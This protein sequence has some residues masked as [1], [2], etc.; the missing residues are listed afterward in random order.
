MGGLAQ[1]FQPPAG[2]NF[3]VVGANG[4]VLPG[5]RLIQP[6][7]TQIETGPG[8]FGLAV[9]PAGVIA[10]ADVGS[11]RFGVTIVEPPAKNGPWRLRHVWARTPHSTAPEFAPPDWT[12]VTAGIAFGA[13]KSIWITEGSSGRIREIHS[14]TGDHGKIV[15]L[16]TAEWTNSYTADLA[17]DST[18]RLINVVDQSNARLAIIDEKSGRALSSV[19]LDAA[20]FAIALSPD[21]LTAYIAEAKAVCAVDLRDPMHPVVLGHIPAPSPEAVLA[22]GDRIYVSNALNDSIT[23]I[24]AADRQV[25]AEISLAVSPLEKFRG[26][27]PA[28]MAYD[29][30][31][32]WLL[33]AE[34][35]L[36]TVGIVDTTTNR[37]IGMIPAAWQPTRVALAGDRVYVTNA[38]GRGTGPNPRRAILELGEIYMLHRGSV[39]TFIMPAKSELPKLTSLAFSLNGFVLNKKEPPHLPP[40]RHVVLIVKSGRTFDEVMGD[41]ATASNGPVQSLRKM[42]VFGIHGFAEGGRKQ[43][44]V[45]D[46]A[47]TP[48]QHEI[49]HRWAF[50]DNFYASGETRAEGEYWLNGGYPDPRTE[51]ALRASLPAAPADALSDHLKSNGIT[52]RDIQEKN[53]REVI[54]ELKDIEHFPQ[55]LRIALH[56]DRNAVPDP[57]KGYP[58]PASWVAETDFEIGQI[59]EYLSRSSSWNDMAVFITEAD[60]GGGLDHV[61]ADRTLLFAAG[62]FVKRDYV[63][64]TN[65]SMPGLLRTIFELLHVSPANLMDATAASLRDLFTED[66]QLSEF[67]AVQPDARIYDPR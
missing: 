8:P 37:Q 52:V 6:L 23:V 28:G 59:L 30:V 10:T 22:A 7:G 13:G 53:A 4:T 38:R 56:D 49:A 31:T 46:A 26:I 35:G 60:A 25:I 39:S 54:A 33:V 43:F 11:E 63:S 40:V 19:R 42:A 29:P 44:S 14:A 5:G 67:T 17:Y 50:S 41:V 34:S 36:N 51:A 15:T 2:N 24:S 20:P 47:I 21:A 1:D 3:A 12:G 27:V 66:T 16:N 45:Q 58:Y 64:H 62:P 55:F 57:E 18:R 32:R 65:A 9:S 48:N 61:D